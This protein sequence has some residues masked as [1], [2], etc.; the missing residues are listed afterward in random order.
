MRLGAAYLLWASIVPAALA[1]LADEAYQI[2]YHHALL[3]TPRT[4]TTF[5]HRPSPSSIAS[6][7]YTHSEKDILGAVNPKDGSLVWRHNISDYFPQA[8]DN[9]FLRAADGDE[10]VVS[11]FGNGVSSWGAAD[12]RFQWIQ[13]FSDGEVR[14]LELV[15]SSDG[16]E[17]NAQDVLVL[18]GDKKGVVRRLDGGLGDLMWEHRDER[19]VFHVWVIIYTT[20]PALTPPA[21]SDDVPFQ[22][23][24][25]SK[26]EA[27]YISLHPVSRTGYKI[28]VTTLDLN[29]GRAGKLYTLSSETEVSGPESVLFVGGN[30]A[31]PLIA[32]TDKGN[33]VLKLNVLGSNTVDSINVDNA[34]VRQI[35][36]HASRSSK[37]PA[38]FLVEYR[39]ESASWA[40]VYHINRE[41][42]TTSK[43]Y[44][45]PVVQ[46][47]SVMSASTS[48]GDDSLYFT[49]ITPAEISIYSSVSDAALGKW[50]PSEMAAGNAQHA[51][52]EV[53]VLDSGVSVR[54]ARVEES[55][56]WSLV[57]NG[58]YQWS[59]PESLTD[60]IASAW[61]DVNDGVTLAHELEVEGHQSVPMAYT[62]R[63]IRHLKDLQQ[64]LPDWLMEM[65]M[66]VL[67]SFMPNDI[68]DLIQFG[69]G[70]QVI[71]A[72]RTGRV[73]M[74]DSGRQ[75]KVMWNIKA[76]ENDSDWG[77]K[78][79]T[80][81]Q[82]LATVH[83]DDG[84]SLQVNVTTGVITMR[85]APTQK[86]SSIMFVPE[87]SSEVKVGVEENG[88]PIASAYANGIDNFLVTRSGEKKILGWHTG[89]SKA[90]MWEF[91]VPEGQKIIHA[92]ARPA[93]D[94][95]ASIGKVLGNRSVLYK[96]L[97]PN[98]ALVTATGESSVDFYLLDGVSGQILHTAGYTEVDTT[99]PIASIISENWFAYSF[100]SDT[101]ERSEAKGYQLIVSELYES[102]LPNDRGILGDAANYSSISTNNIALPHVISQAY[103]IPE[104][105]SN[106][107]VTQTRQ[108]ISIRQLLCTL[109]ASNSIVGIPRPVL[110]P[111]RPVGREPTPQEAEEGLMK[112]NPNLEFDPRWY[113]T[114]SREVFGIQHIES[115]PTLLE[116]TTLIFSYGFDIF[117]TRVAPSQPFD[118]LGKGFSKIQLLLTVVALMA[119]VS[120]LAPL[121]RS[122]QV[123]LL[124]K[125]S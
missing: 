75:G 24:V 9:A 113:L 121:A 7:L 50:K 85:T 86:V 54:F 60:A 99:Q 62:H 22:L 90:P 17:G 23:S 34:E 1:I 56:D 10:A 53:V 31:A 69:F 19:Y 79:I 78:A 72:T 36:I 118:L 119:G 26:T 16:L 64:H 92:T 84:S 29:S 67:T 71:L 11:A 3:G 5:F 116:S 35:R 30:A 48:T 102:S 81:Q 80:T 98:L 101:S 20:S 104:A 125:S 21:F 59:R 122:K 57:L 83:V 27:Y 61:A 58:Q 103:M 45:L 2:D 110:E 18:T 32:W 95:V 55:G 107:A 47:N 124:W 87:G 12:G 13:R 68:S 105:I 94:P 88:V 33:I 115:S 52:S 114:H 40:E 117:G 70:Q 73:A 96:Y 14:D 63:L 4:D 93:H 109:P 25:A 51:T 46:G 123:N 100:W 76:V 8:S 15:R 120:A 77:V 74:L 97:N 108:G 39:T 42:M 43:I 65:P 106:M 111:R 82:G 41:S 37:S 28:K 112:Y 6:L 89:K 38:H 66:R 49:R 91:T 44:S